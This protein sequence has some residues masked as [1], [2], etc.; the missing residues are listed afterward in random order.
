MGYGVVCVCERGSVMVVGLSE[1]SGGRRVKK[2]RATP[3]VRW[4]RG[5]LD[6]ADKT[7][8]VV[9]VESSHGNGLCG[10]RRRVIPETMLPRR[11]S[12]YSIYIYIH[13]IYTL[14]L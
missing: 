3:A 11:F 4:R 9:T 13:I 7:T 2:R 1:C 8:P 6:G 10:S 14:C 12:R 5:N